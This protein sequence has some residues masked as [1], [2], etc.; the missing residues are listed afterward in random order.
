MVGTFYAQPEPGAKP[1]VR[2][3]PRVDEGA[4]PLHHRGDE[5][6]ERDRVGGLGRRQRGRRRGRL[7]RSST[8]RSS[9]ASIRMADEGS[10]VATDRRRPPRGR[11]RGFN[12]SRP[13]CRWSSAARPTCT[14]RSGGRRRCA[15]TATSTPLPIPPLKPE[16]LEALAKQ[17]MT[18]QQLKEFAETREADF[19]IGVPGHRPLPGQRLPAARHGRVRVPRA[20]RTRSRTI[21]RAEAAGGRRGRSPC[22][23]AAWSS[24]PGSRGSGKSTTLASMIQHINRTR[25][26]NIITIE[27]PIEFLHRDQLPTSTSARS[28]PTRLASR[29]AA[30]RAA[31]GPRRHPDRRDS[32]P[33]HAGHRA[34]GGRHRPPGVLDAAHHRR[35]ADD[36]PHPL[37]LSAAP[38]GRDPLAAL[39]RAGG[40]GLAAPRAARRRPG[41]VPACEVLVNTAAVRDKIRDISKTLNIP[42]LIAEGTVQYGMQTFDQSLMSLVQRGDHLV[43]ERRAP[44]DQSERVRAAGQG[45]AASSD[46][47]SDRTFRPSTSGTICMFKKV[48]VAN[49]GEIALRVI[50]ACRELGIQTVAVYSRG[51][52]RVAA[53]ALRRRRCLHRPAAGRGSPTSGFR[54]SDRGRRD[55]RR[56]RDPPRLRLPRRERRVRRDLSRRRTSPSSARPRDQIRVDGRQGLGPAPRWPKPAC[57]SSRAR[58]GVVRRCRGGA[59]VRRG[60]RLPGDHQGGRRRRREGDARRQRRRRVRALFSLAQHR[61]AVGLRQRRRLRREVPR[62]SRATSRSRSS[63]TSTAT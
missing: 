10:R 17:I 13:S 30:P 28:G 36:Q 55:H 57:R 18:P 43:R 1:Y 61:G 5:D 2:V 9:S 53:R 32:R 26:A 41:R 12:F 6:H 8:A 14:S 47:S 29:R 38:A 22:V 37:V 16:D 58:P 31:T 46:T 59:R 25:R 20:S 15:S 62:A 56:R 27:D 33:R 51:R 24:S 48:L 39:D 45:V 7:S 11:A 40:G 34:Q 19:A 4:D 54:E 35:D 21:A 44:R 60:D 3:G 49:R 63:A 52:S 50:R 23:R 42:D